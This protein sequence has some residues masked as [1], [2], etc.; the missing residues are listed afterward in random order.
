VS[1]SKHAK[2][3]AFPLFG[4]RKVGV[5]SGSYPSVPP[6]HP[7]FSFRTSGF[8][9]GDASWLKIAIEANCAQMEPEAVAVT[10]RGDIELRAVVD[11]LEGLLNQLRNALPFKRDE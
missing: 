5:T 11:G 9:G 1:A 7:I 10:F 4:R 6:L 2:A 8:Q 3:A